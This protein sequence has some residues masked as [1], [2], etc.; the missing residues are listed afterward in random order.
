LDIHRR[1]SSAKFGLNALPPAIDVIVTRQTRRKLLR[2]YLTALGDKL[3]KQLPGCPANQKKL[4]RGPE[5]DN[6]RKRAQEF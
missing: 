4:D 2:P 5:H 3:A 6:E 1:L